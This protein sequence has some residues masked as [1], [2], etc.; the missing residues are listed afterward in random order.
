[1]SI[2]P[3]LGLPSSPF[4]SGFPTNILYA[5]L[6]STIRATFPAYLILLDLNILITFGEEYKL[7]NSSLCSF[8]QSPVTSPLF[9][10]NILL[11]TL[12]YT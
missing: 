12:F 9:G 7:W 8:L 1:L 6:Y 5:F 3:R 4:P 11:S 10:P 2:H